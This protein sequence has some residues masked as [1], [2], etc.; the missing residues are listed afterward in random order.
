MRV[1]QVTMAMILPG[2]AA[3]AAAGA[4][5]E[6]QTAGDHATMTRCPVDADRKAQASLC[7]AEGMTGSR[8]REPQP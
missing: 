2:Y 5:D 6:C 1:A 4:L 3:P 7:D 8:A